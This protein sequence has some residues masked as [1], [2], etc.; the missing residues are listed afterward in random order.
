VLFRSLAGLT[1]PTTPARPVLL[2][3]GDGD[4]TVFW[5]NTQLMHDYWV[6][7]AVPAASFSVLDL[8]AA[9]AAGDPYASL[10]TQ[11][12]LAKDLIAANAIAQGATDGGASAVA[13]AYHATLVPPFC[14][15]AVRSFF[16]AH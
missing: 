7:R 4:P 9:S 12:L 1:P 14:F 11:F 16:A 6:A 13:G 3:G 8:D 2:C 15:A 10:K 5:L